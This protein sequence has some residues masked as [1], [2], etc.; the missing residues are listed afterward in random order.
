MNVINDSKKGANKD[1]V[2]SYIKAIELAI[3]NHLDENMNMANGVY[4]IQDGNIVQGE[5]SVAVDAKGTVPTGSVILSNGQVIVSNLKI[6]NQLYGMTGSGEVVEVSEKEYI[7]GTFLYFNPFTGK[8]CTSAEAW[9]TSNKTSKCYRWIV[10][11]GA[12]SDTTVE[13]IV[14]HDIAT[15]ILWTSKE[16]YL[17]MGGQEA[18]YKLSGCNRFG[19][20]TAFNKMKEET[21]QYQNVIAPYDI[22][23]T[24][25]DGYTFSIPYHSAKARFLHSQERTIVGNTLKE[26]TNSSDSTLYWTDTPSQDKYASTVSYITVIDNMYIYTRGNIRPVIRVLKN[27]IA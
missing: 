12:K 24:T 2:Y 21:D 27:S 13:M 17:K 6:E 5:H 25:S 7:S 10:V 23:Q 18:D 1:S 9:T 8:K 4:T 20:V 3:T 15:G 14:D 11:N 19:P 16:D 22:E 26:N